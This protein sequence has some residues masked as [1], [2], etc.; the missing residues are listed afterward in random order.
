M[1]ALEG[2]KRNILSMPDIKLLDWEFDI[3]CEVH[4]HVGDA[5][6]HLVSS[7]ESENFSK[8]VCSDLQA[9]E[10]CEK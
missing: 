4:A 5:S 10:V 1:Y 8:D 3:K 2:S 6:E 7:S 9:Y